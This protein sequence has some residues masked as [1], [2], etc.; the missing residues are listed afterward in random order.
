MAWYE[1]VFGQQMWRNV[2]LEVTF[3]K[4]TEADTIHRRL[5]RKLN[6]TTYT[7][8]LQVIYNSIYA[9]NSHIILRFRLNSID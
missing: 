5:V 2:I 9:P 3:W 4:H 6:E 8:K 1:A 7:N